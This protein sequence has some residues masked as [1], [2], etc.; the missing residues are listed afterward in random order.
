MERFT[1][2]SADPLSTGTSINKNSEQSKSQAKTLVKAGKIKV[3]IAENK[4][5]Q[6]KSNS[7]VTSLT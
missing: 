7:L 1:E 4:N 5:S 3:G 2:L 6:Q